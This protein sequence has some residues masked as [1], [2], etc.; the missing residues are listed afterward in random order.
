MRQIKQAA[1][2]HVYIV[3]WPTEFLF[4]ERFIIM[5]LRPLCSP[6][7]LRPLS[8][9]GLAG[10]FLVTCGV[11]AA[12]PKKADP[13]KTPAKTTKSK[14]T[15]AAPSTAQTNFSDNTPLTEDQKIVHVLNRLGFGPRPGDVEKVK[16]IGLAKY[17]DLQLHPETI[18]DKAVDAKLAPFASALN[19]TGDELMEGYASGLK[20]NVMIKTLQNELS[21]G[22]GKK[23]AAPV[24]A[25]A[26]T[27]GPAMATGE[28]MTPVV[29]PAGEPS[30]KDEKRDEIKEKVAAMTDAQ[31]RELLQNL[32]D[33]KREAARPI[34]L[35]IVGLSTAKV[36][37]A[38]D[39]NKQL[40][41]VMVDFWTNHFNIDM[42][43][44][45]C[46]VLK[47]ADDRDVARK[48]P[49][50]KFREILGASAHSPAMMVY[51]DNAQSVSPQSPRE[52]LMDTLKKQAAGGN[53][54]SQ[55]Q[56]ARLQAMP[57][58]PA[59]P[60]NPKN[61]KAS[62]GINENYAREIMELHTLGVDGGYTQ[63]DVQEVARCFTGWGISRGNSE[64]KGRGG[65]WEFHPFLHDNGEKTVLGHVIPAG[66]GEKDGE[67][68]LDILAQNPAT[69]RFVSK[70]LCQRFVS[71]TPP[72]SLID[73]CV[74]TWKKTGGDIRE[75][76]RTIATSPEFYSRASYRQKIKSPFEYAVSSVRALGADFAFTP[77]ARAA[78]RRG[79]MQTGKKGIDLLKEGANRTVAGQV[80]VMGENLFHYPF[81]TGWSEDSRKWVSSGALIS[82]LNYSLALVAGQIGQINLDNSPVLALNMPAGGTTE[83][84]LAQTANHIADVILAGD[85]SPSTRAT[86]LKEVDAAPA[87]GSPAK[88][89]TQQ[90]RLVALVLGSPEFQRR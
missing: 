59:A 85:V 89:A 68:V 47:I 87:D 88:S 90:A 60:A 78:N 36:V 38:S 13:K 71:D 9:V 14:T 74:A 24:P 15:V 35:A 70:K 63:K 28:T 19:L 40:Q 2:R 37:R 64:G 73:K 55:R 7:S 66:G 4:V 75:I 17:I 79:A 1:A 26:M 81:P 84:G 48:Y 3:E 67:I 18:D 34:Q 45:T 52:K 44:N 23:A 39:S 49:L 86:L 80:A 50:Q 5:R 25:A 57:A 69:M 56:L 51:L 16:A 41:E 30:R 77:Q 61:K 53:V 8:C 72:D 58:M 82:R 76:V 21:E 65:E 22:K 32:Q 42:S 27:E 62:A 46:R 54:R 43:K 31:K 29:K 11:L 20:N 10:C 6:F 83:T 12:P 33:D